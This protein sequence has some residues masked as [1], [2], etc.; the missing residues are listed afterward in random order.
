MA[1]T[2]RLQKFKFLWRFNMCNSKL[3]SLV[4]EKHKRMITAAQL[5]IITKRKTKL[6]NVTA[7]MQATATKLSINLSANFSRHLASQQL[8]NRQVAIISVLVTSGYYQRYY[9]YLYC[10]HN[11][12]NE[13]KTKNNL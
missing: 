5:D 10:R 9:H 4:V 6:T 12:V 13:N 8:C 1:I 11:M 3:F 7:F 2:F